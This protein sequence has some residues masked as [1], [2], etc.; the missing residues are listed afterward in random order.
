MLPMR[1]ALAAF[2]IALGTTPALASG[3]DTYRDWDG[4][5]SI[6]GF[7]CPNTTT[8]GQIFKA[9]NNETGELSQVSF[10]WKSTAGSGSV[11][12][13]AY[14][15]QWNGTKAKGG[16]LY[17]SP[18]QIIS[19][20]D[21]SF[22]QV[23]FPLRAKVG[24]SIQYVIFVSIDR[25]YVDCQSGTQIAWGAVADSAYA[26]GHFVFQNNGGDYLQ[27]TKQPWI[28][29]PQDLATIAVVEKP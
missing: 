11:V 23:T 4:T 16:E 29:V 10:W 2:T 18:A 6:G 26:D 17:E 20:S 15:Y 24:A 22:H 8:F 13:R 27:W 25:E 5:T 21:S 7:G 9:R 14:V 12:A 28:V 19:F 3:I 1:A